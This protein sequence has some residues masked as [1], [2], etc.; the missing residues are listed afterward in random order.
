[1]EPIKN[2]HYLIFLFLIFAGITAHSQSN[3][4]HSIWFD[5]PATAW[6]SEALPIGNGRMGAILF[7]GVNRDHIQFNEQSLW[8]GDNNWDGAYETGDHGFGSYRN[9][10]DIMVSFG[11]DS[12]ATGY[13][14]SLDIYTGIH[15]TT[16]AQNGNAF[17]REAF[18]NHPD[19]VLVFQYEAKGKA[20]LSGKV[21]MA[22]AQGATTSAQDDFLYF[23]GMMP[24]KLKY[25]ARLVV[26]HDGGKLKANGNSLE[27]SNCR[28]ITFLLDARTN[29]KPDFHSD[30]R[31]DDPTPIIKM[32]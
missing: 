14:R 15:T 6:D 9:F 30:W 22:S 10:G 17:S 29:Y 1:M 20:M 26:K 4:N 13:K 27:F 28:T 16:F 19:Q 18:A 24:N 11:A 21:S 7:G 2:R 23:E 31:G 8:S 3:N 12:I 32:N 25:A 5:K